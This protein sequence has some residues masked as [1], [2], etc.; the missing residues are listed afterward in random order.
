MRLT[1][2]HSIM[3]L[4]LLR[5]IYETDIIAQHYETDVIAQWVDKL[6]VKVLQL[7]VW[8]LASAR[9]FGDFY[10]LK[11]FYYRIFLNA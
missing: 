5:I 4:T 11:Q 9:L 7:H 8:P 10:S 6:Y 2:L 3:R 1:L